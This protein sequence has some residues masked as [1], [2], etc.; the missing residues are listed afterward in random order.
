MKIV[1]RVRD[2][3]NGRMGRENNFSSKKFNY[4]ASGKLCMV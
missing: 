2:T 1:K 3:K 4:I